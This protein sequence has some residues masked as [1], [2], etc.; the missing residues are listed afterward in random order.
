MMKVYTYP[1]ESKW[2]E[3]GKRP[4]GDIASKEAAIKTIL[5]L[6]K[7]QGDK[8]LIEL[9]KKFDKATIKSIQLSASTIKQ[10]EK[11]V[12]PALKRAIDKAYKN[13][14]TFHSAQLNNKI[15]K[16]ETMPGVVCWRKSVPI[17]KVGLY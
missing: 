7:K 2:A 10:A 16:I 6:V 14:F 5:G 1:P 9:Y 11:K 12:S 13:I 3:L 8:A 15:E 17:E 4:M